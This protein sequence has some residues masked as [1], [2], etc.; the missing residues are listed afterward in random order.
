MEEIPQNVEFT[1]KKIR[2]NTKKKKF[3]TWIAQ[4]E[5]PKGQERVYGS[6]IVNVILLEVVRSTYFEGRGKKYYV[7]Y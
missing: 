2:K 1:A 6:I 4:Y 3:R 7:S 5:W